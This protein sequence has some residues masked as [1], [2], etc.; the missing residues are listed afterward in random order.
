MGYNY[1]PQDGQNMSASYP[2]DPYTAQLPT[3]VGG[4]GTEAVEYSQYGGCDFLHLMP[5]EADELLAS[6]FSVKE[7]KPSLSQ[8]PSPCTP[9]TTPIH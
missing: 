9:A 7:T 6:P 1:L 8:L 4:Y 2:A 3:S 5:S